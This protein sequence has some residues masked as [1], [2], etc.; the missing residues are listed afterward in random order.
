MMRS[1]TTRLR[2]NHGRRRE[3]KVG[4]TG[5]PGARSGDPQWVNLSNRV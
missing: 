3:K 1:E 5:D 2:R 4:G